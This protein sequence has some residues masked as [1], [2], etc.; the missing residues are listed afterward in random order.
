V[1]QLLFENLKYEKA[2]EGLPGG[3]A[4]LVLQLDHNNEHLYMGIIRFKRP[5]EHQW[6]ETVQV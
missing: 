5:D 6:V 2:K 1:W 3:S 4:Y